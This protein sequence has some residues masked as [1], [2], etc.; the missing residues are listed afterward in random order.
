MSYESQH[1]GWKPR[2]GVSKA[3]CVA[4]NEHRLFNAMR[5]VRCGEP[6]RLPGTAQQ[7]L[8]VRARKQ[9]GVG[10]LLSKEFKKNSRQDRVDFERRAAFKRAAE[11]SRLKFTGRREADDK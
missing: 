9:Y 11:E 6:M 2:S 3:F 4:C 1:P 10:A 8:R 5:C 7:E